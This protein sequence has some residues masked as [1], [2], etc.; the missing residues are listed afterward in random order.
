MLIDQGHQLK[1]LIHLDMNGLACLSLEQIKGDV[2]NESDLA[3][4][5]SGCDVVFHL[6]AYISIR[7]N[8]PACWKVN[9]ESCLKLIRAARSKGVRRI[10]H[11]SSIHAFREMPLNT[12]L[13]ESRELCLNSAISYDYSKA[14]SQKFMLEAASTDPEIIVLNPT[15]VIGPN[16]FRPSLLGNALIRFYRGQNPVLI[17]GGYNWVD[18]GDVCAAAV[19][20]IECGN[21]G[22]CYLLGGSWQSLDTLVQEIEKLGGHKAPRLK[23]PMWMA[24]IGA[25]LINLPATLGK[26]DPLY[27]SVSLHTLKYSHR[28]ISCEKAGSA[29]GFRSRP[30]NETLCNTME[31]F[32]KN[33]Y[34]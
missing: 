10:I 14:W 2:T 7:K 20:A 33:N 8:D 31:W 28:N 25:P 17:P 24:Q 11:F 29:L 19:N 23:I 16:D 22:E 27:T 30:F 6:A 12:E 4:L 34:M 3:D 21:S 15:A 9:A 26:K 18:V 32:G 13:N 5:C 1:V